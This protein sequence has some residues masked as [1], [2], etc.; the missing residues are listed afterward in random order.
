M[1]LLGPERDGLVEGRLRARYTSLPLEAFMSAP[2]RGY[3]TRFNP[4][5]LLLVR[6]DLTKVG[7]LIMIRFKKIL[8]PV[9]FSKASKKAVNYALSFALQFDSRLILAH[10]APFDNAAYDKAKTAVYR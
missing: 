9:D 3:L 2:W 6:C 5:L 4:R 10:I 7:G 8:V 1:G